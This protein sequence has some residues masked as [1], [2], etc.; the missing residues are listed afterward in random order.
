MEV[1]GQLHALPLHPQVK[2]R[3]LTLEEVGQGF[4]TIG[5]NRDN[6]TDL[7]LKSK[8]FRKLQ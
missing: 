8:K 6:Y 5:Q 1:S 2:K 3:Y 7:V 4:Y